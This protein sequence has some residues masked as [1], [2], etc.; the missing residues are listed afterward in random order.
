MRSGPIL[1]LD[2]FNFFWQRNIHALKTFTLARDSLI[3]GT[4]AGSSIHDDGELSSPSDVVRNIVL[5][6]VVGRGKSATGNSVFRRKAF[7]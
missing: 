3:A 2:V 4:M 7:K 5:V 1:V 6:G